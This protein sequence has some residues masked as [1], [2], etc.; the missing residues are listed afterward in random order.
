MSKTI[1]DFCRKEIKTKDG[2]KVVRLNYGLTVP[3]NYKMCEDC[4]KALVN[5]QEGNYNE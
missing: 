3:K 1:C 5:M 2:E 4:F